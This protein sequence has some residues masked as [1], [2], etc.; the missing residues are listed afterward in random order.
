MSLRMILVGGRDDANTSIDRLKANLLRVFDVEVTRDV[1]GSWRDPATS[2]GF[3]G[4]LLL[5]NFLGGPL[6]DASTRWARKNQVPV[7]NLH[8]QWSLA[9]GELQKHGF[10]PVSER[11][12][13]A[14]D[15]TVVTGYRGYG[16]DGHAVGFWTKDEL[17]EEW[18][19]GHW[20][21]KLDL[22]VPL[23]LVS[24]GYANYALRIDDQYREKLLNPRL[25]IEDPNGPKLVRRDG[26]PLD[27]DLLPWWK[28]IL[29]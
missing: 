4:V 27:W 17:P 19:A 10:V 29:G 21:L 23:Y 3:D 24:Q 20:A 14:L 7:Y 6:A 28:R 18:S 11:G 22:P 1:R 12:S 9:Y 26:R 15:A 5:M 2:A 16:P 13:R 25:Y 8:L